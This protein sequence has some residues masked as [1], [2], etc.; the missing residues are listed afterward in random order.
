MFKRAAT[1][2]EQLLQSSCC[3]HLVDEFSSTSANGFSW[4]AS[5]HDSSILTGSFHTCDVL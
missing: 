2:I 5:T 1:K 3:R 4:L